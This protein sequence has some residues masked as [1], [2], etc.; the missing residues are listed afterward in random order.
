MEV[1]GSSTTTTGTIP[2][3]DPFEPIWVA[4]SAKG[5]NGWES[6]RTN[7]VNYLGSELFNCPLANDLSVATINNTAS[8]FEAIC[9]TAPIFSSSSTTIIGSA[10]AE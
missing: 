10:C 7:A 5:G 6:L 3:V 2:I 4:V 8:D 9:N 1:V